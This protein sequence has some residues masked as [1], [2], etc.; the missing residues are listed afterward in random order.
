MALAAIGGFGCPNSSTSPTVPPYC[1]GAVGMALAAICGLG[2]PNSSTSEGDGDRT[3][4]PKEEDQVELDQDSVGEPK[5]MPSMLCRSSIPSF[6]FR[7]SQCG[8]SYPVSVGLYRPQ[9]S[10]HRVSDDE[11]SPTPAEGSP[12]P[13]LLM[14][15][16]SGGDAAAAAPAAPDT[17]GG[18]VPGALQRGQAS[19]PLAHAACRAW[20]QSKMTGP[21]SHG[22]R[23]PPQPSH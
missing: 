21:S 19:L 9:Q 14:E 10:S 8:H 1:D 16:S 23:L 18:R 17:T 5:P 4:E 15:P 22:S 6:N 12:M 7:S 11:S 20:K 2:C 3:G 13:L